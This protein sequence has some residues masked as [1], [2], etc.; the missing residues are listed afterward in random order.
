VERVM[1]LLVSPPQE[2]DNGLK[3]RLVR[4]VGNFAQDSDI[5]TYSK[6]A[7]IE[8]AE[9]FVKEL[10]EQ[11]QHPADKMDTGLIE[12][13]F[14]AINKIGADRARSDERSMLHTFQ[15]VFIAENSDPTGLG[16]IL[17]FVSADATSQSMTSYAL[18]AL[19]GLV[20]NNE[21]VQLKISSAKEAKIIQG[22]RN[23]TEE[24]VKARAEELCK[25]FLA[26]DAPD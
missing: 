14:L 23:S 9:Y 11:L 2:Q 26:Q 5:D 8:I 21:Q 22:L 4:L 1:E 6:I 13:M 17:H 24:E 12:N 18:I 7:D 20:K 10:R 3:L 15:N 19:L 16:C 25:S